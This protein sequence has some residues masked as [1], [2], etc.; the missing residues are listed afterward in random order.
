VLL[1]H[2]LNCPWRAAAAAAMVRSAMWGP[3]ATIGAVTPTSST[4]TAAVPTCSA[5]T[6]QAGSLCVASRISAEL[7]EALTLFTLSVAL[8]K[9][10]GDVFD[11]LTLNYVIPLF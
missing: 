8:A 7:V 10:K 2:H 1:Q 6:E 3:S 5:S 9:S 4:S 11:N